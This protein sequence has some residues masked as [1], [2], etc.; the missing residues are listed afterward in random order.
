[1]FL[2]VIRIISLALLLLIA[3]FLLK[4]MNKVIKEEKLD[5][6]LEEQ[7]QAAELAKLAAQLNPKEINSN[8]AKVKKTLEQIA[9][10]QGSARKKE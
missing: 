3:L 8:N 9:V 5:A 10:P 2:L 4:K 1:M 6:A 7:N